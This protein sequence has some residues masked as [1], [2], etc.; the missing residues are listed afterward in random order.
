MHSC[1][2]VSQVKDWEPPPKW[3]GAAPDQVI[4]QKEKEFVFDR[5]FCP[6]ATQEEVYNTVGKPLVDSLLAGHNAC[7]FA[8][9]QTGSGKTYTMEGQTNPGVMIQCIQYLCASIE[10]S[11]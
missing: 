5:V 8:Y 11:C 10:P 6:D 1:L 4:V 3:D 2:D 9:G 7:L